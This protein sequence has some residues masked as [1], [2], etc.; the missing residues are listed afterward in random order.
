MSKPSQL[1]S[2]S[3]LKSLLEQGHTK[4]LD[5][6]WYLP[7]QGIDSQG[8]FQQKHIPSA[9]F[10]DID[11]IS[12]P[13]SSLPHMLPNTEQFSQAVS[14]LGISNDSAIVVYDSAGLFSAARV[15]WTFKVFGHDNVRVLDGGL[16]RWQE[17]G[18]ELES[19]VRPITHTAYL[20][21][22]NSRLVIDK[23]ALIENSS[24][25]QYKVL[26]ARPKARFLGQAP[27][28]RPGLPSGHMP[29][30]IS[31]SACGLIAQGRLKRVQELQEIFDQA[32]IGANTPVVTSCGSGVT[33]AIITLAL[34]ESGYG[35][36]KL[37]DGSWAEWAAATDTVILN[38]S[39]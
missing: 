35:L 37:Y 22:F 15:W 2:V 19:Q 24:S 25:K 14:E 38:K 34:A 23:T 36:N 20:A 4:V 8:E 28:P 39:S 17:E 6:S 5:G 26:D 18:G 13:N 11:L 16:P 33:A 29:E 7:S 10:F 27:E 32:N 3:E 12:D 21:E 30:S 1:C 31:F 9:Q